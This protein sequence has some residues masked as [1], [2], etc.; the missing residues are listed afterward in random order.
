MVQCEHCGARE[1]PGV[2]TMSLCTGCFNASYCDAKCQKAGRAAH[3]EWCNEQKAQREAHAAAP[4]TVRGAPPPGLNAAALRR[5]ANAGNVDAMF[6][7][8]NCYTVGAGGVGV[9]LVEAFRWKKKIVDLPAPP[10]EA[11]TSLADCYFFGRGTPKDQAEA[12]RL[13]KFAAEM[14]CGS[15]QFSFARCLQH[16]E[17]VPR[18]PVVAFTWLKRAADAGHVLAQISVAGSLLTGEGVAEDH[19][20]AAVYCRRAAD[21]GDATAMFNLGMMHM[22]SS[23]LRD[24]SLAG[25]WLKR[26][27]DAGQKD[28]IFALTHL[29]TT[30]TPAEA[31]TI[32]TDVLRTL[33]DGLA[34]EVPP[35]IEK[36]ELVQLVLEVA[37]EMAAGLTG[38]GAGA[39]GAGR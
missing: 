19:A 11:Y 12:A 13:Y 24:P 4:P 32:G 34:V 20:S 16:G 9:N 26:A 18:D 2:S 1:A 21:Q 22:R 30:L 29:A 25:M 6:N 35:R 36:S 17:G 38:G 15:A 5:A 39:R 27:H 23:V 10:T 3:R 14:G 37:A 31:S 7:V 33:L 28:A 8:A